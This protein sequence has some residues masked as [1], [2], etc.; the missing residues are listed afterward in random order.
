VTIQKITDSTVDHEG[1]DCPLAGVVVGTPQGA[2][3]VA[4]ELWP[5]PGGVA[6]RLA[7]GRRGRHLTL[8]FLKPQAQLLKN[9]FSLLA[10]ALCEPMVS[11]FVL[12]TAAWAAPKSY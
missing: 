2:V 3:E 10:A 12:A 4:D 6:D 11:T 8:A 5:L 1:P 9:R 7:Q